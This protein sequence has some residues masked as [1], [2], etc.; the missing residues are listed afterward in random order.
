MEAPGIVGMP[1]NP[2]RDGYVFA[3]WYSDLGFTDIWDFTTD[4]ATGEMVIYA[5]WV[6]EDDENIDDIIAQ[7]PVVPDADNNNVDN[8]WYNESDES[9]TLPVVT[10]RPTQT[11]TQAP[12]QKP[13]QNNSS[14]TEPTPVEPDGTPY[15]N[16]SGYYELRTADDLFWFAEYVNSGN[17]SANAVL[18]NN[19]NLN[20]RNWTPIG[21]NDTPY[22]GSFNGNGYRV[23]GV[24]CNVPNSD[25]VGFFGR[26][27][28]V[29]SNLS[30]SGTIIGDDYVGGVVGY[31]WYGTVES[32]TNSG[33]VSGS[34][35]YYNVGGVVG[36]NESSGIV[37][38][39]INSG[40]VSGSA[41]VGGVVGYNESSGIV[42]NC[43][44][45]VNSADFG[46]GYCS[47]HGEDNCTSC[48]VTAYY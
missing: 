21:N 16:S 28:G 38:N 35:S 8:N 10:Q 11:P 4:I 3:G 48:G 19:I 43:R 39:C 12:A 26:S 44:Y 33:N 18:K 15:L 20:S 41:Y 2:T 24:Y 25:Y 1:P 17:T 34:Y 46:I 5:K 40:S 23:S 37:K 22:S 14:T 45:Y 9:V 7:L 31:N 32:C 13:I 29:I 42:E 30:V 6:A 36:L 47:K 27:E